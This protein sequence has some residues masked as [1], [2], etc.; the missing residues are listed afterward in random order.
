LSKLSYIYNYNDSA[1]E[2]LAAVIAGTN[3]TMRI[4]TRWVLPDQRTRI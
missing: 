3:A 4:D 2:L 1:G